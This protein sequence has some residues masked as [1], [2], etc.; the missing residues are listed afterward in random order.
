M[1]NKFLSSILAFTLLL[2]L[3]L[4]PGSAKAQGDGPTYIVEAGDTLSAIARRF[5]TTTEALSLQNNISDPSRIFPGTE[6][7]IPGFPGVN[8]RLTLLTVALGDTLD[9]LSETYHLDES[10]LVHLNRTGRLD[11]LYAGMSLIVPMEGESSVQQPANHMY[12]ARSG[13]TPLELGVRVG[14]AAWRGQVDNESPRLWLIPGE[15]YALGTQD[16][17]QQGGLP[18][19]ISSL[20]V[21]PNPLVQGHTTEIQI[22]SS[23][24]TQIAGELG[25]HE[26]AIF[27]TGADEWIGLQGIH[28][29]AEPGLLDFRLRFYEQGSAEPVYEFQQPLLLKAGGYGFQT[30]NGVPPE[31]VDPAVTE[32]EDAF[33]TELLSP[34]TS[35]KL[36]QGPF[37]FPSRY[38]TAEFISTFG[39]RRSYNFGSLLY[40]HTG[41]DFYG[42]DVPVYAAAAGRVVFA[43]PLTVRGNAT[44]IDHGWGVYSGYLHQSEMYVQEGDL[45]EAGQ[46]IGKVGATGRVTG[47]HLH[48]EI[49]VGDVPIQPLDWIAPGYPLPPSE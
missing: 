32:P 5:G 12:V 18:D 33:I 13:E 49:W 29:L 37:E 46:V 43:G 11:R 8:G 27:S 21:Y 39:T 26:L 48:W 19:V 22:T 14:A 44:Y 6:L 4:T 3:V 20:K 34:A 41:V 25:E 16:A 2:A 45:V 35:E 24:T 42:Q 1:R 47:P 28:A 17:A 7:T 40:Y 10:A 38:Y 30:L 36:W 15:V 31:T 9:S 23:H